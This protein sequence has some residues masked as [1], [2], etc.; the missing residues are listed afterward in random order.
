MQRLL[1]C[2]AT[3]PLARQSSLVTCVMSGVRA[4][5]LLG[6]SDAVGDMV[7][8]RLGRRRGSGQGLDAA[9]RQRPLL[10]RLPARPHTV[11]QDPSFALGVV[12]EAP[13]AALVNSSKSSSSRRRGHRNAQPRLV[14]ALADTLRDD[15]QAGLA[16]APSRRRLAGSASLQLVAGQTLAVAVAPVQVPAAR[17]EPANEAKGNSQRRG[18]A[19]VSVLRQQA[20]VHAVA[21]VSRWR[22]SRARVRKGGSD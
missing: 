4:L 3:H 2:G 10:K 20:R 13:E 17:R 9:V 18:R 8:D 19:F 6:L 5:L 21:W 7:R 1:G 14:L 11:A 22:A 16:G 15:F 12:A